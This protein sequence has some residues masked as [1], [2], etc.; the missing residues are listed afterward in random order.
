MV[1]DFLVPQIEAHGLHNI[2]FQQD[3]ATC[4]TERVT[5]DLLGHHFGEQLILSFCPVNWPSRSCHIT[6]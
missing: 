2:W 6:P 3:V 5:M 1:T 4:H